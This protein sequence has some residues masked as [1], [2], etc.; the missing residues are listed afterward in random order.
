VATPTLLDVLILIVFSLV[1]FLGIRQGVPF[2]IA[3]IGSV[4]LYWLVSP[5]VFAQP[6]IA[7]LP[8]GLTMFV[9]AVVSAVVV[10]LTVRMLPLPLFQPQ[11]EALVGG[12][13]GLCWGVLMAA[14]LWSSFPSEFVPSTG[15]IRYPSSKASDF[16]RDNITKSS[17]AQP[18]FDW[19]QDGP[20]KPILFRKKRSR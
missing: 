16:V 15:A 8:V 9:L 17:F 19:V 7:R 20:L 3:V 14:V 18:V 6:A 10:T 11:I 5:M 13:G 12:L 4:L 2:T 1:L